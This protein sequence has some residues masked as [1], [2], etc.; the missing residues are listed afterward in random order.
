MRQRPLLHMTRRRPRR[1]QAVP[2][3]ELAD[4]SIDWPAERVSLAG[5]VL[6][7]LVLYLLGVLFQGV[8]W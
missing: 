3:V 8:W 7:I 5:L 4:W 1:P 6:T 2:M